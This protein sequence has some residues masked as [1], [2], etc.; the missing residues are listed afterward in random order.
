MISARNAVCLILLA[1]VL[2]GP[3]APALAAVP[4]P[5]APRATQSRSGQFLV[6]PIPAGVVTAPQLRQPAGSGL[7]QLDPAVL[8]VLGERIKSALLA[9][10]GLVDRWRGRIHLVLL[11]ALHPHQEILV[12]ASRFGSGWQYRVE[13][14]D[15]VAEQ[16]F[17][18]ALTQVL[19]LEYA[20]RTAQARS[21][22]LP[23]WLGEGLARLLV[24]ERG[25]DL[26]VQP[27]SMAQPFTVHRNQLKADPFR[28][29]RPRLQVR[30]APTFAEL[31]WPATETLRDEAWEVFQGCAHL[32][33]HELLR[34]RD[35]R[36]CLREMLQL[37]PEHLNWQTAFLRACHRY[38]ATPLDVEKW[39]AVTLAGFTGRTEWQT[40]P[41]GAALERLDRIFEVDTQVR[42]SADQLP[43]R[44]G[45][46]LQAVIEQWDYG[47]QKPAIRAVTQ[48]LVQA[49]IN[50][51]PVLVPL[52]DAYRSA[53]ED[54]LADRDRSTAP[55]NPRGPLPPGPQRLMRD[56]VRRLNELDAQREQLRRQLAL[57]ERG[58]SGLPGR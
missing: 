1:A 27:G 10:L 55:P 11:P 51:P 20:N 29:L 48:Q 54:Y 22:E 56:T 13:I 25:L 46:R 38:F 26:L 17:I 2:A 41:A 19:L 39:W 47:R 28:A 32:F 42:Q 15:N 18:R 21:A 8:A 43:T 37:L 58:L 7:L 50:L 49:R 5:P 34:L 31:S 40:W 3:S 24:A 9:E 57:D 30:P 52:V 14:P 12:T 44:V 35:G 23:L 53:L 33:V 36:A 45:T 16:R 6:H 4:G